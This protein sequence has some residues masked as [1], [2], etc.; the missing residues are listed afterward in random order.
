MECTVVTV[1]VSPMQSLIDQRILGSDVGLAVGTESCSYLLVFE[2][3]PTTRR[4]Y[5][6]TYRGL[7]QVC[8]VR[9]SDEY[10]SPIFGIYD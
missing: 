5:H 9:D 3:P 4:Q 7:Q 8:Y 1:S 10:E 2:S 6:H